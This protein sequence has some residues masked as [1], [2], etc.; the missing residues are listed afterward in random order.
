[1]DPEQRNEH[2]SVAPVAAHFSLR[3]PAEQGL[4]RSEIRRVLTAGDL[5]DELV[6]DVLVVISE[7]W[8]NATEHAG[9]DEVTVDVAVQTTGVV[10]TVS[11]VRSATGAGA[12]IIGR[13]DAVMPAAEAPRG[14]GLAIV[15]ALADSYR[16][17]AAGAT[18]STI[19]TFSTR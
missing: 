2:R 4:V 3:D 5:D 7:L 12:P 19:C 18:V 15:D 8:S 1:M 11:Y 17:E 10:T 9:A 13:P 14:R 16:H 6:D